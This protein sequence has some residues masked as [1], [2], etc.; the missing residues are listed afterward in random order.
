MIPRG[1]TVQVRCK[2]IGFAAENGNRWRSLLD[3][4]AT[5]FW[6]GGDAVH[7]N[8]QT[9]GSLQGAPYHDPAAPEC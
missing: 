5:G 3:S 6:A 9:S 2:A 7:N 8:G 1:T 4:H